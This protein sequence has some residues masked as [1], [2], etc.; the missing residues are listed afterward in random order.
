MSVF[1]VEGAAGCGKTVRLMKIVGDTLT[2]T[3]LRDGQR[4]LAL[5]FMHGARRRLHEKLRSVASL[6]GQVECATID[7]FAQRLVRR[8]RSLATA[9][10]IPSSLPDQFDAQCDAAGALLERPEVAAWVA[11][12][13]PVVVVDEAQDLKP[14]RL[15][16]IAA[17]APSTTLLVAADEFQCLDSAL[18]PNPCV[19]WMHTACRPVILTK[20]H[21][22]SAPAL[23]SAA[24]S[25]RG[26]KVAKSGTGFNILAAKSRPMAAFYLAN[27]IAWHR[28]SKIAIITPSLS[29]RFAS[30]VVT[31]VCERACGQQDY[32]PFSIKWDRSAGTESVAALEGFRLGDAASLSETVEALGGIGVTAPVRATIAWVRR[33][34]RAGGATSFSRGE[35]T[36]VLERQFSS[37]HQRIGSAD[38]H[39]AA[40][41]VHQAKNREFEGVV[42]LWPF[43]T[44]GDPEHKRRLLYNAVTRARRWCTVILEGENLLKVPPFAT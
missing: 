17:L 19:T 31:R 37:H 20:I 41:T 43:K 18:H 16:M 6:R 35:V 9:V 7:S 12:S 24:T 4:V 39:L 32:G 42:I 29:G 21:R 22:T 13:F 40:M 23:L 25:I 33:Q 1:A 36:A 3:P 30:E 11:V 5:T 10:G 15:R 38:A 8:W 44:G 27:A 34:A 14:E 2:A 28:Q 26:G